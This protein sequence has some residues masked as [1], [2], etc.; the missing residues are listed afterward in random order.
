MRAALIANVDDADPGFVGRALRRR[1]VS[2]VE[3]LR[4]QWEGW[5]TLDGID[6]V[7]AMGSSWSVYWEEQAGPISAEQALMASA[8]AAGIPV[9]GICFGAQQLATVL[10]GVV[11][12]AQSPEIGWFSV[13]NVSEAA[14]LSPNCLTSGRWM[15]WHYDKFSVPSGATVLA[16]SPVGP[17]AIVCGTSLGL[18]F[19]P[20]ASESIV[21]QWSSGEGDEELK[22][23]GINRDSLLAETSATV[24]DAERRCDE[25]VAWFLRDVA[26]KHMPLL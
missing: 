22:K 17:Q 9:L 2:F 12:N 21:R 4:E 15:Q 23:Q 16:D 8:H 18:Q 3:Y 25:L 7:V 10:G 26:Q 13:Q 24:V 14:H 5:P 20:E 6:L 11:T 19:H 1:G